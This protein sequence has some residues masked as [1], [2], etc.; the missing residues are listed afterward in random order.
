MGITSKILPRP[1]VMVSPAS[2]NPPRPPITNSRHQVVVTMVIGV[3]LILESQI[4]MPNTIL[5]PSP[6]WGNG[7][8]NNTAKMDEVNS[9]N[10][11]IRAKDYCSE[12][13]F[14]LYGKVLT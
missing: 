10:L 12:E 13:D 3:E 2:E 7:S 8:H 14:S 5:I 9:T 1:C 11:I 4:L 6:Q